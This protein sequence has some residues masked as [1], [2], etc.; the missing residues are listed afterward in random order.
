MV[1]DLAG[2]R[3]EPLEELIDETAAR[4]VQ[5]QEH[6]LVGDDHCP[7]RIMLIELG[8]RSAE[9][10]FGARQQPEQLGARQKIA[11]QVGACLGRVGI[12]YAMGRRIVQRPHFARAACGKRARRN[13]SRRRHW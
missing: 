9:L 3:K 5:V 12:P 13:T 1:A 2:G 8:V 7:P 10:A 4:L 11:D 6:E